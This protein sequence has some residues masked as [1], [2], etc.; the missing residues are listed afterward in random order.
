MSTPGELTPRLRSQRTRERREATG[1]GLWTSETPFP[2]VVRC[3]PLHRDR[4]TVKS[5]VPRT[6]RKLGMGTVR[7]FRVPHNGMERPSRVTQAR[8][9]CALESSRIVAG[10]TGIRWQRCRCQAIVSGRRPGPARTAF[11]EPDD[12]LHRC[13]RD[14]G[15]GT[16]RTARP[17]LERSLPIPGHQPTDQPCETP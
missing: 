1:F 3:R 9:S 12:Q 15:R 2:R 6:P 14:R 8:Q 5:R 11:T 10:A 7:G 4:I 13:G 17:R 16:V